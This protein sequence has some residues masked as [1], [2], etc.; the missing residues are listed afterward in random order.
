MITGFMSYPC[1]SGFKEA[2][3]K[4]NIIQIIVLMLS[5]V[6]LGSCSHMIDALWNPNAASFKIFAEQDGATIKIYFSRNDHSNY[7]AAGDYSNSSYYYG[8]YVYRNDSSPYDNYDLVAIT[9]LVKPSG[10]TDGKDNNQIY[11]A[12]AYLEKKSGSEIDDPDDPTQFVDSCPPPGIKYFYRVVVVYQDWN[13]DE[14][15]WKQSLSDQ[16]A[17]SWAAA[18]CP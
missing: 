12:G 16:A 7:R 15:E 17:S 3:V 18:D 4:K 13:K 14:K 11:Y 8:Y 5:M 9:G 2:T 6:L 10:F 1:K